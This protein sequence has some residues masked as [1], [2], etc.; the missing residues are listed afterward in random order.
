MLG[1]RLELPLAFWCRLG[2]WFDGF[3]YLE[4]KSVSYLFNCV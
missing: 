2:F 4:V 3:G 1:V